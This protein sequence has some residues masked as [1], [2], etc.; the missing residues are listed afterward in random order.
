MTTKLTWMAGIIA[1]ALGLAF[2]GASLAQTTTTSGTRNFEVIAVDGNKLV[3]RD[4][5]GTQEITVPDDFRFTVDGKKMA[6]AELKPGMKGTAT[7]TTTTTIKPVVV[8]EVRE[9]EVLRAS[10]LSVTVRQADGVRRYTREELDK[11]GIRVLKDG[12]PVQLADLQRGD[13]LTATIITS[14]TPI[15]LTEQEVQATLAESKAQPARDESA[16]DRCRRP[17]SCTRRHT[18]SCACRCT[19]CRPARVPSAGCYPARTATSPT[20]GSRADVVGAD[21][22]ARRN[23][24]VHGDAQAKAAV[25]NLPTRVLGAR[26]RSTPACLGRRSRLAK[27]QES[28]TTLPGTRRRASCGSPASAR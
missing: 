26:P 13:K 17:G 24:A 18:A 27:L 5:K 10:D 11:R 1:V 20:I 19:G 14:G 12:K 23:R 21:R 9:A 22:R 4:E 3:V 2:A 7:I 16:D 28:I 8:S 6:V 15:T 25:S